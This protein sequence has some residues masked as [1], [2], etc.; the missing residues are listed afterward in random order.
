[1]IEITIDKKVYSD[2]CI[3]KTVYALSDIYTISRRIEGDIEIL[4]INPK[5]DSVITSD[6]NIIVWD[7]LNDYKLRDIIEVETH[8]IR[9]ILYAKAFG[10]FDVSENDI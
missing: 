7:K 10:D 4:S 6:I 1:M 3:S 5:S 8:D 9:M 2:S